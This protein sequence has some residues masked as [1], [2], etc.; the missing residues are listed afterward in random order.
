MA[1][2][3]PE[4][5]SRLLGGPVQELR[6]LLGGASRQTWAFRVGD[7]RMV[8][9]HDPPGVPSRIGMQREAALLRAAAQ[10]GLAVPQVLAEGQDFVV[11]SWVDG[12]TLAR[13][14]LRD[15]QFA[16]ARSRLVAQ[17]G[18]Q[19]ARLHTGVR[20]EQVPGLPAPD[21]L[22]AVRARLDGTGEPHPA[23]E[24]GLRWLAEHRPPACRAV[25]LHGDFRLGN[26]MVGPDGLVGVLDWELAHLG[27]PVQ[28]LAWLCVRSW[29]FGAPLPV[30]GLG[31]REEL[32]RAYEQAG[33]DP[34]GPDELR[35]WEVFG[36]LDWG[37]MCL[38]QARAHLDG[39][40]RSVE[41][42]AIGRRTCEVELD[43]LDLL[44]G[45]AEH[46]PVPSVETADCSAPHDRPTAGEL[47]EAVREFLAALPL[48]GHDRFLARVSDRVL[49]TVER[50]LALGP[51]LHR[52]HEERLAALGVRDDAELAA[53]LRTGALA[54]EPALPQVR[55]AVVAKLLV[56]D[57]AQLSDR[58]ASPEPPAPPVPARPST[59][60]AR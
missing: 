29:R 12:E 36:T 51:A 14:I 48:T 37:V 34:V 25:V 3:D 5:L 41:L 20:P 2:P 16:S 42:A 24:L 6:G 31:T 56:A 45:G 47:L 38:E 15:E 58:Y 46:P 30:A 18:E 44:P 55:A 23:L 27:D 54:V 33:G 4:E 50:E 26:L 28:D 8:L 35:W 60:G 43:L 59:G 11:L 13:R 10:A 19:L 40:V 21:P 9:R 1:A 39:R 57:P 49:R 22:A 32:C 17:C 7:R 53:A 52:E